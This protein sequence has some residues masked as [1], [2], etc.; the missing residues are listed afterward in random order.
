[1][2]VA[3]AAEAMGRSS[4][5]GATPALVDA[6][7]RGMLL[8][9]LAFSLLFLLVVGVQGAGAY[10]V[11]YLSSDVIELLATHRLSFV[12]ELVKWSLS[13]VDMLP[14]AFLV[15][16]TA[17]A[18]SPEGAAAAAHAQAAVQLLSGAMVLQASMAMVCPDLCAGE[19]AEFRAASSSL[20][21]GV[22]AAAGGGAAGACEPPSG[23]AVLGRVLS[24][25][26]L[27]P[28]SI[29]RWLCVLCLTIAFAAPLGLAWCLGRQAAS[30]E[31]LAASILVLTHFVTLPPLWAT[32]LAREVGA[33]TEEGFERA[34]AFAAAARSAA[35]ACPA[36][37][38]LPAFALLA[39]H[40]APT[41]ST[42]ASGLDREA[43]WVQAWLLAAALAQLARTGAA[44]VCF[45]QSGADD[46]DG[47]A[48]GGSQQGHDVH[49]W[50]S[51]CKGVVLPPGLP[52][53]LGGLAAASLLLLQE[54]APWMPEATKKGTGAGRP[55]R[56]SGLA[57]VAE[58]VPQVLALAAAS[59]VLFG[60]C[61]G[62]VAQVL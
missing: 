45:A 36:L 48:S 33:T 53:G 58:Q 56:G 14:C 1:L 22:A 55:S 47:V 43:M 29:I 37:T 35:A 38:A 11:M 21:S 19:L 10:L 39:R 3:L 46:D 57:A 41:V 62:A 30:L 6:S 32:L 16:Q 24:K 51:A 50:A 23:S 17:L 49:E 7:W 8:A 34:F 26:S 28:L 61:A 59:C 9:S 12:V 4:A 5:A 2:L 60:P 31:L 13:S 40:T 25:Y 18:T 20:L 52:T 27:A 42:V 44:L 54:P 15:L